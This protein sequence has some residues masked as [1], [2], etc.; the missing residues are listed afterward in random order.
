MRGD[1]SRFTFDSKKHYNSVR[2]QQGRMQLDAD[3]NEA[4][5]IRLHHERMM[6]LDAIGQAGGPRNNAGFSL[7]YDKERDDF[8]IG[9]GRY[10]VDGILCENDSDI[11]YSEQPYHPEKIN[12]L[13]KGRYLA[14]L[15]LWE[16]SICAIEDPDIREVAL[17]GPDTTTRTKVMWRLELEPLSMPTEYVEEKDLDPREAS[18]ISRFFSRN[19]RQARMAAKNGLE[20]ISNGDKG[21]CSTSINE[22]HG[23]LGNNL[24]RVEIHDAGRQGAATFKWSRDNCSVIR[25]V[26]NID[27]KTIT[28]LDPA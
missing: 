12:D 15:D 11:F 6:A 23:Y 26:G 13:P 21:P 25:A 24:Y 17:G 18:P 2:M 8:R 3:W 20:E 4:Q 14:Y 9:M 10:Y 27:K 1:F 16:S 7:S 19:R 22:G 5:D 28:L